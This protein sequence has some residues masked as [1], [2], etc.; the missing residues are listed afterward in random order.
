MGKTQSKPLAARHVVCELAFT[1]LSALL[2]STLHESISL[3]SRK[4]MP[5]IGIM[6]RFSEMFF[7][8]VLR[9][10]TVLSA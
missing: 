8:E 3:I 5:D 7:P 1:P 9:H 10:M 2:V 6:F 4:H